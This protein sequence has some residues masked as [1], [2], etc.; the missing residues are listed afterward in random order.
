MCIVYIQHSHS[1]LIIKQTTIKLRWVHIQ[2]QTRYTDMP[3]QFKIDGQIYQSED[4]FTTH[5]TK[6]RT[7]S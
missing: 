2:N 4:R 6:S 1:N 7:S 5:Y 3:S